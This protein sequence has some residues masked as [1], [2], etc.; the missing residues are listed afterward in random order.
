MGLLD[1]LGILDQYKMSPT[2]GPGGMMIQ[3]SPFTRQAARFAGGALGTEMRSNPEILRAELA[4]VDPNS[5]NAEEQQLAALV[6]FGSPE[7]Q[8][9]ATQRLTA[10]RKERETTSKANRIEEGTAAIQDVLLTVDKDSFYTPNTLDTVATLQQEYGISP[11]QLD[12]IYDSATTARGITKPSATA[13]EARFFSRGKVRD[14]ETG[15]EY[16]VTE[17]VYKDGTTELIYKNSKGE[18]VTPTGKVETI[19]GTTGQSGAEQD[20]A[21]RSEIEFKENLERETL[22]IKQQFNIGEKEAGLWLEEVSQART[23]I[24]EL[25]PQLRKAYEQQELLTKIKTGGVVPSTYKAIL[26][27]LGVEAPGVVNAERFNKLA[28]DQMIGVLGEFGSNPTEGE[29]A[30]AQELV[31]SINDLTA[32]N[33]QTIEAYIREL[34]YSYDDYSRVLKKGATPQSVADARLR[35]IQGIIARAKRGSSN[36]PSPD[37]VQDNQYYSEDSE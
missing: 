19:S 25:A 18:T 24:R 5:P 34:Q 37:A 36:L 8:V 33:A 11:S 31:A 2:E 13:G 26:N 3:A 28:K 9:R 14:S 15:E 29:R 21:K 12:S 10:L 32:V 30:S 20:A 23:K 35:E 4:K 27:F 17:A 1:K 22:K 7:Q 16:F 6:K